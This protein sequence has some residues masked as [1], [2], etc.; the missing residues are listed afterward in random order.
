[1]EAPLNQALTNLE[2]M[3]GTITNKVEQNKQQVRDYKLKIINRLSEIVQQLNQLKENNN[4]KLIPELRQKLEQ[5][6]QTLQN[7]TDE[8]DTA[9]T[10]LENTTRSLQESQNNVQQLNSKIQEINNQIQEFE[11][12]NQQKDEEINNL[13]NQLQQ[14]SQQKEEAERNSATLQQEINSLVQRIAQITTSLSN[15]IGLIDQITNELGNIEDNNDGVVIQFKNISENIQTIINMI[16]S[17]QGTIAQQ[18]QTTNFSQDINNLYNKF[19]TNNEMRQRFMI[20]LDDFTN[21]KNTQE[22]NEI[23]TK[24]KQNIIKAYHDNNINSINIIKTNLQKLQTLGFNFDFN[25]RTGGK[26]KY[27]TMKKRHRRTHKKMRGGYIYSSSKKLDKASSVIST[28]STNRIKSIP[29]ISKNDKTRRK[30]I[31]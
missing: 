20:A 1:M 6:Q 2:T 18:P 7:K 4:I 5:S 10:N 13:N 24:I 9:K 28:S 14:L 22:T 31:K 15:Q 30:S 29:R 27:K 21:E 11:R 8:L 12:T 19:I 26:R 23:N 3:I 25:N 17:A 16:N